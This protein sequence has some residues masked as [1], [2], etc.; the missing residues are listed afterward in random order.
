VPAQALISPLLDEQNKKAIAIQRTMIKNTISW[1]Q[2]KDK[3]FCLIFLVEIF[4]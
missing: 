4:I 1:M 3:T 2:N